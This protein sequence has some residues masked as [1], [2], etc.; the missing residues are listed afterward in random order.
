MQPEKIT[1][2]EH[3]KNASVWVVFSVVYDDRDHDIAYYGKSLS[4]GGAYDHG[5]TGKDCRDHADAVKRL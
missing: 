3:G 2:M 5:F 4:S 1:Q